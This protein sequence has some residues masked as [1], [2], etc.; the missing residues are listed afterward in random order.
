MLNEN[1]RSRLYYSDDEELPDPDP[2][3]E[4]EVSFQLSK[5]RLAVNNIPCKFDG[6]HCTSCRDEIPEQRL[7]LGKYRCVDCQ[8][9]FEKSHD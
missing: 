2:D 9:E 7:E 3:Y 8:S 4:F 6:L 1:T 5:L